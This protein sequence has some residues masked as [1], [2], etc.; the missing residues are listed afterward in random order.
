MTKTTRNTYRP[1]VTYH[2]TT[3]ETMALVVAGTMTTAE[4]IAHPTTVHNTR[5]VP[6]AEMVATV[7]LGD[8]WSPSDEVRQTVADGV[9]AWARCANSA[10]VRPTAV[11]FNGDIARW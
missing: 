2:R 3:A 1:T 6:R 10:T 11:D 5:H 8:A 7:T 4:A 9:A